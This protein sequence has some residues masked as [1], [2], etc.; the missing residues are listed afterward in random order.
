MQQFMLKLRTQTQNTRRGTFPVFQFANDQ[1]TTVLVQETT[2]NAARC[3]HFFELACSGAE[4]WTLATLCKPEGREFTSNVPGNVPIQTLSHWQQLLVIHFVNPNKND[5]FHHFWHS[6]EWQRG[7]FLSELVSFADPVT[8]VF[9]K[10][11]LYWNVCKVLT[12][13]KFVPA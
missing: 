8:L 12:A 13:Q 9:R 11:F 7:T 5:E 10:Q 1:N 2:K 4:R 3:S 6:S